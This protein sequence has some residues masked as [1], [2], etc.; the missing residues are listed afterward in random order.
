ITNSPSATPTAAPRNA[1]SP[2]PTNCSPSLPT[3]ST[4][5]FRPAPASARPAARGPHKFDSGAHPPPL[6]H[7]SAVRFAFRPLRPLIPL[8][9]KLFRLLPTLSLFAASAFAAAPA[10]DAWVD[11]FTADWIRADPNAAT[12]TQYFSGAEQDTLD[13]QLTPVTRQFRA[14]R[15]AAANKGLR[16]EEHTSELQSL[17]NL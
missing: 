4:C 12:E 5:T 17:T 8:R 7:R 6:C 3:I 13:R 2:R 11:A 9:M 15:V 10:F 14:S 16:S 1:T